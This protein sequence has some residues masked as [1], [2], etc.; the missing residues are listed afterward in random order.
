MDLISVIV[1]IYKV[2]D[3]LDRCVGSIV[4]QTYT[5]LEII[6]VDDGS[7]DQCPQMCNEWAKKDG[8]IKVIH[9]MNGGLSDARNAG[10]AIASGNFIGFVDSDDWI[11][12]EMY[13]RL[14]RTLRKD[15][16]DVAACSVQMVWEDDTP[17]RMLTKQ[18]NCVLDRSKAQQ[19]L[20]NEA[21]LKQPVWYKLYRRET[22][23]GIL[24]EAGK[25]HEDVFWSYQVIGNANKISIIDYVGYFYWQRKGS[26]MYENYSIKRLDALEAMIIRQKYIE[27]NFPD[28]EVIAKRSLFFSCIYQYQ[29]ALLYLSPIDKQFAIKK[30]QRITA[31]YKLRI[32]DLGGLSPKQRIW[33]M[34]ASLSIEYTCRLRNWLGVGV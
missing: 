19:A 24:F 7:P 23:D 25:C 34:F 14:Y 16:S 18:I 32:S 10:M 4:A 27:E 28:L 11:A 2:E 1:P 8:R 31:K 12:P 9:K 13:E 3:Y 22:I 33:A 5:E 20:L 21:E 30:I 29:Q 6:L 26:I 15:G 17:N